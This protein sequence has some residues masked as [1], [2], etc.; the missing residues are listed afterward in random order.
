MSSR[1]SSSKNT[2][3][4]PEDNTFSDNP[5]IIQYLLS[6][7]PKFVEDDCTLSSM[8]QSKDEYSIYLILKLSQIIKNGGYFP[9]R[10][11]IIST[12]SSIISS[13][14][15]Q[16]QQQQQQEKQ[17]KADITNNNK[18][19]LS[20]V[21]DSSSSKQITTTQSIIDLKK[22]SS[23]SSSSPSSPTTLFIP[24]YALFQPDVK[25]L[26]CQQKSDYFFQLNAHIMKLQK[27]SYKQ[28]QQLMEGLGWFLRSCELEY[29]DYQ[30]KI[31]YLQ[32]STSAG[33]TTTVNAFLG[34]IFSFVTGDSSSN[35][36]SNKGGKFVNITKNSTT[37]TTTTTCSS[38]DL[39]HHQQ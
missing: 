25:L 3:Q 4:N 16:Q 18:K 14:Q 20:S 24:K 11:D 10:P 5:F 27:V 8:S 32:K 2:I 13:K 26:Y 31:Q 36:A 21:E 23:S 37:A 9:T 12:T 30:E 29:E 35:A 22:S 6:P 15:Q 33:V 17:L 39:Q 28:P 7:L 19:A 38:Q 34:S 1:K